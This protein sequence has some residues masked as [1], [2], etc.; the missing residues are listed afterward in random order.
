MWVE[1]STSP[2]SGNAFNSTAGTF[3]TTTQNPGNYTFEYVLN[4]AAP[5]P[6]AATTVEVVVE[7]VPFAD[8][9]ADG[10]LTCDINSLVLGGAATSTGPEFSYTWTTTNGVITDPNVL[11]TTVTKSGIYTLTVV[12]TN[13][14]CVSQDDVEVKLEGDIPTDLNLVVYSPECQGDPPG[15]AQVTSVIG[16]TPPYVY[17]LNGA[18]STSTPNW[19]TLQA[20]DYTLV[21]TD[22]LGCRYE[23]QFSIGT[24]NDLAAELNG[25][26]LIESGDDATFSYVLIT[27]TADSTVWY[28]DGT[29]TCIN[30]STLV[31]T[32]IGQTVVELT[33][34][35]ERGC[36]I[37]LRTT[38]HVH[39]T[40]NVFVPNIFSPNGDNINDYFTIY[41][42]NT[43]VVNIAYLQVFTRWGDKVFEARD[44]SPAEPSLGW[45]GTFAGRDLMPGV[46][47][48]HA[49][50]LYADDL[51]EIFKGDL[52]LIR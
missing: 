44:I 10:S 38:I 21:V 6:D 3:R 7:N 43:T 8:A 24:A 27:G 40:R 20:G 2:S 50:V 48:Y 26:I 49:K 15:S 4:G 12:N 39:V 22:N 45:D 51:E 14:G 11:N 30:C 1:T 16:G 23:T 47:V 32:P 13:T 35:D 42:S 29:P 46:Y 5:C 52:T 17:T 34:Y 28:I 18:S 37:T 19:T 25:E 9:G 41:A 31:F 33:I 36:E